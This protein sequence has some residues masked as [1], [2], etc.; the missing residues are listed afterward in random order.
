MIGLLPV[1]VSMTTKEQITLSRS[2]E[3]AK[4]SG[5]FYGRLRAVQGIRGL[6][7]TGGYGRFRGEWVKAGNKLPFELDGSMQTLAPCFNCNFQK[8]KSWLYLPQEGKILEKKSMENVFINFHSQ[9][10]HTASPVSL[11]WCSLWN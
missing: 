5:H 8:W 10:Q 3:R 1:K 6:S 9:L 7:Y 11:T 4:T 2:G